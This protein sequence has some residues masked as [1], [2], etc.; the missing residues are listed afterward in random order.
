MPTYKFFAR[1]Q[2]RYF[3]LKMEGSGNFEVRVQ[4]LKPGFSLI[5]L[6]LDGI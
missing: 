5:F 3:F 2:N 1:F 4:A 6:D